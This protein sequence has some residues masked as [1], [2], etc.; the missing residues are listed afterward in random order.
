MISTHIHKCLARPLASRALH[1]TTR[2]SASGKDPQLSHG[3]TTTTSSQPASYDPQSQ[4]ARA[5][6]EASSGSGMDAASPGSATKALRSGSGKGNREGVGMAEQVGGASGG[7]ASGGAGGGKGGEEEAT[8]P[9]ILA[10]VKNALGLGTSAGEVKQNRG[11]GRGVTGT[12]TM[13]FG[14]RKIHSS[15]VAGYPGDKT[16]VKGEAG[17][18]A[19]APKNGTLADQNDHL[20]HQEKGETDGGAGNAAP[21]PVLPSKRKEGKE[22]AA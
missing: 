2:A 4:S 8:A 11:G 15:A 21:D 7:S 1:T 13:P 3:H 10:A 22:E 20:Q 6:L 19:R 9:G 17:Y 16:A 12:G 18:G 5:G 14:K